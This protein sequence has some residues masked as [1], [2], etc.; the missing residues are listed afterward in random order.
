MY[1]LLFLQA[2]ASV[3][4]PEVKKVEKAE[5]KE[6]EVKPP[7]PTRPKVETGEVSD[8]RRLMYRLV[9]VADI[10]E[11]GRGELMAVVRCMASQ[12]VP[13]TLYVLSRTRS[14]EQSFCVHAVKLL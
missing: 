2:L 7:S 9:L 3:R 10:R 12:S 5:K 6:E 14:Y 13:V 1:V 4:P 11:D 8:V